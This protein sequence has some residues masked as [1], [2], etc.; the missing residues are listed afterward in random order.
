MN[1]GTRK[2]GD[3]LREY[4]RQKGWLTASPW[5]P[6]FAGWA[7][8]AGEGLAGH[9]R[10]SDVKDG[11]LIVE[12]DH[13]GWIQ[14][15]RLRQAGILQAARKAAPEASLDGIRVILGSR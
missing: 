11:I 1:A 6:L 14:V 8:I 15:A 2:I 3:L 4:L 10:L 5:Q 7:Q 12:V 13:P 9:S